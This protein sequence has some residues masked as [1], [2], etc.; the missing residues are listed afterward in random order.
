MVGPY[1]GL[2]SEAYCTKKQSA[3]I[4]HLWQCPKRAKPPLPPRPPKPP[5]PRKLPKLPKLFFFFFRAH[6]IEEALRK[7]LNFLNPILK[8]L[9]F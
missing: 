2:H 4:D 3:K 5:R 6:A 1:P 8:I 9:D 7:E